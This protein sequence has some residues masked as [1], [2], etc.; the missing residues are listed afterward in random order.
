MAMKT[1][2]ELKSIAHHIGYEWA[3]LLGAANTEWHKSPPEV[4]EK[5]PLLAIHL[6]AR[7]ELVWLHA[8]VLYGFLFVKNRKSRPTDKHENLM[9]VDFLDDRAMQEWGNANGL[10]A[11][12]L[13]PT[14]MAQAVAG[15]LA[16]TKLMHATDVRIT[17]PNS[18][19]A[20]TIAIDE[21]TL[22][23]KACYGLMTGY[24]RAAFKEGLDDDWDVTSIVL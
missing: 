17:D 14:V 8:R 24:A 22:A 2:Q 6:H 12:D 3:M 18:L 9:V 21:L 15:G 7:T 23:F 20:Y 5:N 16:N 4:H 10:R 13:C 19:P 11:V 1:K